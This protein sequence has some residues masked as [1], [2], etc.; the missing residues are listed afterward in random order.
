MSVRQRKGYHMNKKIG[1]LQFFILGHM[2]GLSLF[3]GMGNINTVLLAKENTWLVGICGMIAGL[4]PILI[5][6]KVFDIMPDKNIIEKINESF[7]NKFIGK[8]LNFILI[9]IILITL[10]LNIFSLGNFACTKY[11]TETPL[12]FVTILFLI[13]IIY[14]VTK[15]LE[16]ISRTSQ[17]LF[18]M[19]IIIHFIITTSLSTFID[20]S[21]LKPFFNIPINNFLK[22]TFNFV[23]YCFIPMITLLIIPKNQIKNVKNIRKPLIVGYLLSTVIMTIVFFM[24]MSVVGY[25]IVSLY[26]NPEYFIMKKVSVTS[27]FDNVENFFS[28]CWMF[29]LV[30]S[31]IMGIYYVKTYI[32]DTFKIKKKKT[33]NI[34][35]IIISISLLFISTQI[36]FNITRTNRFVQQ[37]YSFITIFP[38]IIIYLI[39]IIKNSRWKSKKQL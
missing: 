5:I 38:V 23:T 25:S 6:S 30:I 3:V 35:L 19:Y 10:S 20:L 17:I 13:P 33:E 4:I 16:V 26:R 29:N 39:L 21:N 32:V 11:L 14:A 1:N 37:Y 31:S 2:V 36:L 22:A 12:W 8:I 9:L 24:N 18:Y 34:L 7:K 28:L 15:G 27:A